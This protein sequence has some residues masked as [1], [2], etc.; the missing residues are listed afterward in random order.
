MSGCF[1]DADEL[2]GRLFGCMEIYWTQCHER[3]AVEAEEARRN[4]EAGNV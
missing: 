4:R 1:G 2:P 3:D